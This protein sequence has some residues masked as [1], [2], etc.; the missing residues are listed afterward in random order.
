MD[1][2]CAPIRDPAGVKAKTDSASAT[3]K[4][5]NGVA[6][7]AVVGAKSASVSVPGGGCGSSTQGWPGAS[8]P[9]RSRDV[10]AGG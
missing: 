6:S 10:S 9:L 3:L 4:A 7:S 5:S 2:T 8:H 1:W